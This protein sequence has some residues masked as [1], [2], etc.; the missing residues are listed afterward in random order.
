MKELFGI[1]M[2]TLAAVLAVLL[3]CI[4]GSLGHPRLAQ[5]RAAQARRSQPSSAAEREPP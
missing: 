5:P 3:A 4:A 2:D 1:P